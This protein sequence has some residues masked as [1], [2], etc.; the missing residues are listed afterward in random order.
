MSGD[1]LFG[2]EDFFS[3]FSV[4]SFMEVRQFITSPVPSILYR[5]RA[6]NPGGRKSPD[7]AGQFILDHH[8][9][10]HHWRKSKMG[11]F[12]KPAEVSSILILQKTIVSANLRNVGGIGL[13]G[14]FKV[15]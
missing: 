12:R 9:H 3:A 6:K 13:V 15:W 4:L 2:A 8:R 5:M 7:R 1:L 14:L 11:A 10:D